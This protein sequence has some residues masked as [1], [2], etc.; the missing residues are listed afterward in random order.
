MNY[1]IFDLE[2]NQGSNSIREDTNLKNSECPFEIIQIGALKLDENFHTISTL[3]KLI[4]PKIYNQLHPVVKNLTG[5]TIDQL[6][7]AQPFDE[8]YKEFVEFIK[9]D[10]SILC[11]WGT[12][13][14]KEL[15]RN[16]SYHQLSLSPIP[17]EYI[18]IQSYA[19]KYL[20]CPKG[21][22]IG[23]RNTVE[24]LN[25]TLK[26]EFHNAFNDAYYTSEIFK[27]LY[28]ENMESKIYTHDHHKRRNRHNKKN[29]KV[30]TYHLIQQFEKM[31]DRKITT[32]EK[33]IIKLAYMMGK[34]NQFQIEISDNKFQEQ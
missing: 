16:I 26:Q 1:I 6:N 5:I 30:D 2:F 14:I 11:V 10:R 8:V 18:N 33:S 28:N 32:E 22:T 25:I 7:S 20:N 34:T 4:K 29:Q 3:D 27:K 12:V 31:F 19:S 13:D 17:K 23:L 9:N 24:L 15:L 21:T